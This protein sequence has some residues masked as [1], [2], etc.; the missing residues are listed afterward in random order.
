[1]SPQTPVITSSIQETAIVLLSAGNRLG[2]PFMSG[3]V[4]GAK[5]WL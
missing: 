3:R 4:Q 2:T 1:M 5:H